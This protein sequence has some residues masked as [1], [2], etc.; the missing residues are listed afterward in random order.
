MN[1][2]PLIRQIYL[3][4]CAL[5]GL[6]LVV[7]GAV[8]LVDMGLKAAIFT[9]AD[10]YPVYPAAIPVPAGQNAPTTAGPS[11]AEVQAYQDAQAATERER[12]AS[13]SI[14]FVL[15]GLPLYLYH[16]MVIKKEKNHA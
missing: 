7:V 2:H 12:T 13:T 3:Y 15:V 16:W 14:A 5:I 9:G 4:V 6:I 10:T 1:N 8:R 11:P